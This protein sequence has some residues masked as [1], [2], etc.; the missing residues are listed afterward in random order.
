[1]LILK[2]LLNAFLKQTIARCVFDEIRYNLFQFSKTTD[3]QAL[4]EHLL[5]FSYFFFFIF[6]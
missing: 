3:V 4:E 6:D 1:M 2:A 5:F